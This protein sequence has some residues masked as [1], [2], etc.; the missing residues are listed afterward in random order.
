MLQVNTK[1]PLFRL[2][3]PS[4]MMSFI[5]LL[6]LTLPSLG[7]TA[8]ASRSMFGSARPVETE[9][10]QEVFP[11]STKKLAQSQRRLKVRAP[12]KLSASLG[13]PAFRVSTQPR[14]VTLPCVFDGHRI[15]NGS[16]APMRC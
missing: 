16:L 2:K 7:I 9:E 14:A 15:A 8:V 6:L 5:M 1:T 13:G 4:S 12:G 11:C 3:R 10:V